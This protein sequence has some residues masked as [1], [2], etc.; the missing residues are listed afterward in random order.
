LTVYVDMSDTIDDKACSS[1]T[2]PVCIS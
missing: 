1:Y 2:R